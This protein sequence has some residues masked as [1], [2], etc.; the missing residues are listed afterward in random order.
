[1]IPLFCRDKEVVMIPFG[2]SKF[3]FRSGVYSPHNGAKSF[4]ELGHAIADVKRKTPAKGKERTRTRLR[5]LRGESPE[6]I[7][8]AAFYDSGRRSR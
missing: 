1:M 3:L 2:L 8:V 6:E 7:A 4:S 5:S